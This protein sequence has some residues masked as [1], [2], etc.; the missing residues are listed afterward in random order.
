MPFYDHVLL[1]HH[2]AQF[3]DIDQVQRFMEIVLNGLSLNSYM[4]LDE[5]REIIEWYRKFFDENVQTIRDAIKAEE[6]TS[7]L[8]NSN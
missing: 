2:L 8:E 6:Y 3:P 1:N 4:T 7:S 5:K